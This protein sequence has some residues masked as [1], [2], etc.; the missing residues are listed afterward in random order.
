MVKY[1]FYHLFIRDTSCS[2]GW[3][4]L[5][6]QGIFGTII[7][8]S[9]ILIVLMAISSSYKNQLRHRRRCIVMGCRVICNNAPFFGEFEDDIHH[10]V[11]DAEYHCGRVFLT[12]NRPMFIN[13]SLPAQ[14]LSAIRINVSE[15]EIVGGNLEY[16]SP[17]SF[18]SQFGGNLRALVLLKITLTTIAAD[19]FLGLSTLQELHI[20][21]SKILNIRQNALQA[22]DDTLCVLN[23]KAENNWDP[24]NVTGSSNFEKL[25][26]VDFSMNTFHDILGRNS[27][28]ELKLCKVLYLNLCSI[29]AIGAGAFDFLESIEILHLNNNYLTSLPPDMFLK[30]IPLEPRITL[31]EN[32]WHCSCSNHNLRILTKL[33][34]MIVDPICYFPI[35]VR[36]L[37]FSEFEYY[38][39]DDPI[40]EVI[41]DDLYIF[42]GKLTS[43][44]NRYCEANSSTGNLP[45]I[46]SPIPENKC[47][48]NVIYRTNLET[49]VGVLS[50]NNDW[51]KP[52]FSI[53][54]NGFTMV[55]LMF[56]DPFD[57]G[58]VWYKSSCPNEIYCINHLPKVLRVFNEDSNIQYTFCRIPVGSRVIEGN[59]CVA[60]DLANFRPNILFYKSVLLLV[61]V[62]IICL[63][64][65]ALCVYAL[66]HRNPILLKGNKRVV[67]VKHK[68]VD[69]LIL[70]PKIPLRC[71]LPD[72]S[73]IATENRDVF[74]IPGNRRNTLPGSLMRTHSIRT[75]ESNDPSYISALQPSDD[76]LAEWRIKRDIEVTCTYDSIDSN[77]SVQ[78]HKFNRDSLPYYS[79]ESPEK[80]YDTIIL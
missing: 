69:A 2:R 20:K 78:S 57:Y 26:V 31:Q 23:I 60:Y 43:T 30:I 79:I 44:N 33:G 64:S 5:T 25:R 13:S 46:H 74:V 77:L 68:T 27:F 66:I 58:L 55:S 4:R 61:C 7:V 36:G 52:Y 16:I 49:D 34:L 38:C 63:L 37:T 6:V 10:T 40:T 75:T 54:T 80:I 51:L 50:N 8:S 32:L 48:S 41:D 76:Q 73:K 35:S 9:F 12:L 62:A 56:N 18:M 39:A 70:P 59:Q 45:I 24:V 72:D 17:D 65:G 29:T 3:L 19:T 22:V 14:W 71:N 47:V 28:T 21:D 1:F 53:E 11:T 15:L 42:S 67:F